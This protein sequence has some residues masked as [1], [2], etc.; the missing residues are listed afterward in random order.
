ML[1]RG[2]DAKNGSP[3]SEIHGITYRVFKDTGSLQI[4]P[5]LIRH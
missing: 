3:L 1:R 4:Y 2:G 5:L